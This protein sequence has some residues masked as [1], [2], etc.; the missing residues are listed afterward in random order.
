MV[1]MTLSINRVV[2][3]ISYKNSDSDYTRGVGWGVLGHAELPTGVAAMLCCKHCLSLPV[4]PKLAAIGAI[5]AITPHYWMEISVSAFTGVMNMM[6]NKRDNI[7]TNLHSSERNSTIFSERGPLGPTYTK[8]RRYT[9][10]GNTHMI[11]AVHTKTRPGG[12][13]G[14]ATQKHALAVLV[15]GPHKNT[16]WRSWWWGHTKTRPG[17]PGG[18][19]A[20]SSV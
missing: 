20:Q 9:T 3:V 7:Y 18:G 17:G 1:A 12:P 19:D 6:R 5:S 15:V 2:I 16:P 8:S 11:A 14:G 10:S 13:G 4:R